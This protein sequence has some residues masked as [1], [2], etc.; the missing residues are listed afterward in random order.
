MNVD[1]RV[2]YPLLLSDFTETCISST[3]LWK[4]LKYQNFVNIRPV[5]AEL[6]R[7]YGRAGMTKLIVNLQQFCD[8][9]WQ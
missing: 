4:M 5:V 2:K 7:S 9:A 3:D 6:L 8:R 1:I